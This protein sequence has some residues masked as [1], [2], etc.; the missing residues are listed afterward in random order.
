MTN[1]RRNSPIYTQYAPAIVAAL[2][3]LFRQSDGEPRAGDLWHFELDEI[4]F[5]EFLIALPVAVNLVLKD[6]AGIEEDTLATTHTLNRLVVQH[7]IEIARLE[8]PLDDEEP[9]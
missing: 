8:G 2:M 7:N 3:D 5:T 4:D 9:A 6:L 1:P